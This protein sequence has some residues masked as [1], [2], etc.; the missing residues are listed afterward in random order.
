MYTREFATQFLNINREFGSETLH[1]MLIN[2]SHN[3]K[4]PVKLT[5]SQVF[6]MSEFSSLPVPLQLKLIYYATNDFND[7]VN[8]MRNLVNKESTET[9]LKVLFKHPTLKHDNFNEADGYIIQTTKSSIPLI[10]D[11]ESVSR[12]LEE[13][14]TWNIGSHL[15]SIEGNLIQGQ[16]LLESQI[17]YTMTASLYCKDKN[18][19]SLY[20]KYHENKM[21]IPVEVAS[22]C[23]YILKPK[24]KYKNLYK[25]IEI[26]Q[27]P[28]V[29][30]QVSKSQK[31][32]YGNCKRVKSDMPIIY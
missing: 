27:T 2:L 25:D 24:D 15:T 31:S 18:I 6:F 21:P 26:I 30:T 20:K 11:K 23:S 22:Q 12:I 10:C 28:M 17:E 9:L 16:P 14:G 29:H 3:P 19:L 13:V 5:H 7:L 1:Y 32:I 4:S 8:R